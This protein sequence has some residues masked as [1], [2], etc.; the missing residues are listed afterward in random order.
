MLAIVA[1]AKQRNGPT[2][3]VRLDFEEEFTRFRSRTEREGVD[4]AA[5]QERLQAQMVEQRTGQE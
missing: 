4:G 2:G 3:D 1:V 5:E